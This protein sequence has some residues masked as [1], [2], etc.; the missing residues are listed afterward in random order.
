MFK[1]PFDLLK[2]RDRTFTKYYFNMACIQ[3]RYLSLVLD[4]LLELFSYT[5]TFKTSACCLF[6]KLLSSCYVLFG[7]PF[8]HQASRD[9]YVAAVAN[10]SINKALQHTFCR[11]QERST[12]SLMDE[13]LRSRPE[14]ARAQPWTSEGMVISA[15]FSHLKP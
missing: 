14:L 3:S 9:V 12:D 10:C 6:H 1:C 13:V 2:H 5:G 4:H 15:R 11:I 8:D 7:C